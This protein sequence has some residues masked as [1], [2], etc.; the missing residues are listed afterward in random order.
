MS[1]LTPQ[2]VLDRLTAILPDFTT[3]RA[4]HDNFRDAAGSFTHSGVFAECSHFVRDRYEQL[5]TEERRRLADFIG[6]CMT[7]PGTDL[8]QA[9][10]TCFLENLAFEPFSKDFEGYVSGDALSFFRRVQGGR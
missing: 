9:A 6:Q 7:P 1:Q 8:D 3:H 2:Q 10:A 5:S 4:S